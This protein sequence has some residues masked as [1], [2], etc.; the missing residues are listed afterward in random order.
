MLSLKLVHTAVGLAAVAEKSLDKSRALDVRLYTVKD[1]F[2]AVRIRRAAL[3]NI[4]LVVMVFNGFFVA[5][6]IAFRQDIRRAFNAERRL[7][8]F[9]LAREPKLDHFVGRASLNRSTSWTQNTLRL[10]VWPWAV[11]AC[12]S[13][14]LRPLYLY[15]GF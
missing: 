14:P 3:R 9:F 12:G 13:R 8:T 1:C 10:H 11:V 7:L 5:R 6:R 2:V 4:V 15:G